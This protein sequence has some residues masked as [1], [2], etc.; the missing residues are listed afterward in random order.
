MKRA[1]Y[2]QLP[3]FDHMHRYMPALMRAEGFDVEL[4]GRQSP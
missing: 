1:S 2:I 3:Y 4:P